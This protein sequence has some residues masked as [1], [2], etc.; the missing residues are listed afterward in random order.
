MSAPRPTTITTTITTVSLA[1]PPGHYALTSLGHDHGVR[2][3]IHAVLPFLQCM[4]SWVW[5]VKLLV[6]PQRTQ[7]MLRL[8]ALEACPLH[9]TA[10]PLQFTS[11]ETPRW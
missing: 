5:L 1:R 11:E 3:A 2:C 10:H 7:L 8:G 4:C 9:A 6:D